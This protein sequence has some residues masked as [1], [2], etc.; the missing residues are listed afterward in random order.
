MDTPSD[1]KKNI[2]NL[3]FAIIENI[4]SYSEINNLLDLISNANYSNPTFRKTADLFAIRQFVQEVPDTVDILFNDKLRELISSVFGDEFFIVKSIYFD[5]PETS[6]WFVAYH[7]DLTISV[8]KKIDIPGF[9]SWTKKHNQFAVQPTLNV[10]QDN[11]TIRIHLDET[12]EHNGALKVIPGSHKKG[13]YRPETIDWTNDNEASP[14]PFFKQN[15][16]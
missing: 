6:N 16:K 4:Y 8:D 1:I 3:G 7:Q 13:V 14:T 9:S 12:T 15:D 11:F 2:D 10:L 5:K